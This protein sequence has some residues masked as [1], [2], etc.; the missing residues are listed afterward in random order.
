MLSSVLKNSMKANNLFFYP[1]A[2][3]AAFIFLTFA[4]LVGILL[5]GGGG[6][7]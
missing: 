2:N 5:R 3:W 4:D 1:F 6:G 7:E